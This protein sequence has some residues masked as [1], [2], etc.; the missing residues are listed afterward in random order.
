MDSIRSMSATFD[1]GTMYHGEQ[2][3]A[4]L[5]AYKTPYR[6]VPKMPPLLA[7]APKKRSA[8]GYKGA[9]ALKQIPSAKVNY[10]TKNATGGRKA[11][12][13]QSRDYKS[14]KLDG[15]AIPW[16]MEVRHDNC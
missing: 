8:K 6:G 13:T 9:P 2:A 15:I 7:R 4:A 14:G 11:T 10:K 5:V 3:W 1:D 16:V 12:F